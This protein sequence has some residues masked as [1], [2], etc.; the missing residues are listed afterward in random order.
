MFKK[1]PLT[2]GPVYQGICIPCN[3]TLVPPLVLQNFLYGVKAQANTSTNTTKGTCTATSTTAK[4][5]PSSP[6]QR[7]RRLLHSFPQ[8]KKKTITSPEPPHQNTLSPGQQHETPAGV[9]LKLLVQNSIVPGANGEYHHDVSFQGAYRKYRKQGMLDDQQQVSFL[10]H[11]S[12]TRW[13][14][15]AQLTNGGRVYLYCAPAT[16]DSLHF[17]PTTCL[18]ASTTRSTRNTSSKSPWKNM[19]DVAGGAS[20]QVTVLSTT[21]TL[22]RHLSQGLNPDHDTTA[23]TKPT[24]ARPTPTSSSTDTDTSTALSLSPLW[25]TIRRIRVVTTTKQEFFV[26]MDMATS[27]TILDFKTQIQNLRGIHLRHLQLTCNHNGSLTD[28]TKSLRQYLD[29]SSTP[30]FFLHYPAGYPCRRLFVRHDTDHGPA[31]HKLHVAPCDTIEDV[32]EKIKNSSW[33]STSHDD[34]N[35]NDFELLLE[36]TAKVLDDDKQSLAQLD[37]CNLSILHLRRRQQA[38]TVAIPSASQIPVV[39]INTGNHSIIDNNNNDDDNSR[40]FN[41]IQDK[42][43]GSHR[44][45]DNQQLVDVDDRVVARTAPPPPP[46]MS[47]PLC[48]SLMLRL[49]AARAEQEER[50]REIQEQ[51]QQLKQQQQPDGQDCVGVETKTA[52]LVESATTVQPDHRP[53]DGPSTN[54][55]LKQQQQPDG[56]D[57]VGDETKTAFPVESATATLADHRPDDSV[58]NHSFNMVSTKEYDYHI[59]IVNMHVISDST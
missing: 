4:L 10:F 8:R 31:I 48:P 57:C 35:G 44:T 9:P 12:A 32:K 43:M 5:K 3:P 26:D 59:H 39:E 51:Q 38:N 53:N 45:M 58:S 14:L 25:S 55:P 13:F 6:L 34:D 7:Q 40:D 22:D 21:T 41:G 17:P 20:L 29:D 16:A 27:P 23:P 24:P 30:T 52:V 50:L 33:F 47:S 49:K 28:T 54:Q 37:L 46:L 19:N 11:R 42:V 15:S 56:R 36:D 1:S 2:S 18:A